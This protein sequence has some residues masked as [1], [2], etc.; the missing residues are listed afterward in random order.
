MH[1]VWISYR[2]MCV[3]F[4]SHQSSYTSHETYED[5]SK[6][7]ATEVWGMTETNPIGSSA[8]RIGKVPDLEKSHLLTISVTW[9]S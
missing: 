6:P 8:K 4:I 3:V 5:T 7:V 9:G 2:F 1:I